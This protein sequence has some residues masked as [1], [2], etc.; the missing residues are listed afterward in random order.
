MLPQ[1]KWLR[2]FPRGNGG[3]RKR[4]KSIIYTMGQMGIRD[5]IPITKLSKLPLCNTS[6]KPKSTNA[7]PTHIINWKVLLHYFSNLGNTS[8]IIFQTWKV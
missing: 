8:F 5:R 2:I 7:Q 3:D 4:S 1:K 6:L